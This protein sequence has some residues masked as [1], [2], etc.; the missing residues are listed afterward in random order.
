MTSS[1]DVG[2]TDMCACAFE[3]GPGVAVPGARGVGYAPQANTSPGAGRS[4][5]DGGL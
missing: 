3:G 5:H 2:R 1:S 4:D